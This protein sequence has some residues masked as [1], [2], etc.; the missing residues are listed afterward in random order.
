MIGGYR[1]QQ[2]NSMLEYFDEEI[3]YVKECKEN[4]DDS[5]YWN[6]AER[7]ENDLINMEEERNKL[8]EEIE[9]YVGT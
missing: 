7:Y 2:L 8:I 1:M 6:S 3:R 9:N 5:D 4:A